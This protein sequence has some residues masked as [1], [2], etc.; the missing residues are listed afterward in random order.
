[1][2]KSLSKKEIVEQLQKSRTDFTFDK[3]AVKSRLFNSIVN[4]VSDSRSGVSNRMFQFKFAVFSLAAL[5]F[6]SS[7]LAFANQSR[8]GD[9]L[10]F[11]DEWRERVYLSLP[12][13][14]TSRVELQTAFAEE[15]IKEISELYITGPVLN[16][17]QLKASENASQSLVNAI[18]HA[19]ATQLQ[20]VNK[21]KDKSV[22]KVTRSLERLDQLAES[23]ERR[24]EE[25]AGN[26]TDRQIRTV[27]EKN[28]Q[29]IKEARMNAKQNRVRGARTEA[30][31]SV[32]I[33]EEE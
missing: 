27:F 11:L 32:D 6:I 5:L 9:T 25:I 4:N 18:N 21:G 22:E 16:E 19:A 10:Y 23:E 13:P 17:T 33:V 29:A 26:T 15:R 28:L 2:N 12:Q 30:T 3:G 8:P 7:T 24:L 20:L 14:E 1:M 31:S